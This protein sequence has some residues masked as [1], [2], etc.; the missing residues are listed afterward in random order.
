M[1]A[2]EKNQTKPKQ[3]TD[4]DYGHRRVNGHCLH[5]PAEASSNFTPNPR[6]PDWASGGYCINNSNL[7]RN[8]EKKILFLVLLI[9]SG[10][11]KYNYM[12]VHV[13]TSCGGPQ[14]RN[15]VFLIEIS[16]YTTYWRWYFNLGLNVWE[17]LNRQIME[18]E[19][20]RRWEHPEQKQRSLRIHC[21]R[22]NQRSE[23]KISERV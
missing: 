22:D 7:L 1:Q 4:T 18:E 12:A 23:Q 2:A 6:T 13:N 17:V 15:N 10:K 20:V 3:Q 16:R 19:Y 21:L 8:H 9:F 5:C 11:Q 14:G